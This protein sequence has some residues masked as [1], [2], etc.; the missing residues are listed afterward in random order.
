MIRLNYTRRRRADVD[1]S[2]FQSSAIVI[3]VAGVLAVVGVAVANSLAGDDG[4]TWLWMPVATGALLVIGIGLSLLPAWRAPEASRQ[5][6][7]PG[8]RIP[9]PPP[10]VGGSDD[11][12]T[13]GTG[14]RGR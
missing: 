4:R 8:E 2:V 3:T 11:T 14:P 1:P 12:Q 9:P 13:V 5:R 7:L 10:S 6:W